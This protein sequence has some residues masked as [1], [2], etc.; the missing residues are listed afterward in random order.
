MLSILQ[1][2]V[3]VEPCTITIK[4]ILNVGY[5][6]LFLMPC[7]RNVIGILKMSFCYGEEELNQELA[8][9]TGK[10]LVFY[11][12]NKMSITITLPV[13][14]NTFLTCHNI[15]KLYNVSKKQYLFSL[16]KSP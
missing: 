6:M 10:L 9:Q 3:L 7:M 15:Q 2:K 16:K 11:E 12:A 14:M 4:P 13:Y 8:I 1:L 5:K